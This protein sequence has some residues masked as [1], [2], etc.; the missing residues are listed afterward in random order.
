MAAV[1]ADNIFKCIFLN[2]NYRIKI[3]ISL[4]FVP[5]SPI[6]NK[7]ALV[8]IMAWHQPGNKP[9]YEPMVVRLPTHVLLLTPPQ[10]TQLTDS[11]RG[12]TG[13][14]TNRTTMRLR[15]NGR[16]FPDDIFQTTMR[17]RQN[18]RCFPDD[19]FKCIFLNENVWILNK[20]SLNFV[21]DCP[22]NNIPVLVQIIAWHRQDD[23]PLSEPMMVRFPM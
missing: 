10:C 13:L 5:R 4:K 11:N 1:L 19:I 22:I 16:C 8:Q 21:P 3:Q 14:H 18:G 15:Q 6:D 7:P 12:D 23:K 2:E 9:L 20:I 17:L